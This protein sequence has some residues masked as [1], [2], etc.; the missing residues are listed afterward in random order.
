[1]LFEWIIPWKLPFIAMEEEKKNGEGEKL[2]KDFPP[3]PT[4][5]WEEKIRAD[6]KGADYEKKLIWTVLSFGRH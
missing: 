6:L 2:F 3:V 5:L 1:M 4:S